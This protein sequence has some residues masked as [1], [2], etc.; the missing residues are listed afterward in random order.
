MMCLLWL[1]ESVS[2]VDFVLSHQF[3]II[4]VPLVL[5]FFRFWFTVDFR[6]VHVR[7]CRMAAVHLNLIC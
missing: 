2:T 1:F 5:C 3:I 7:I 4:H 6:V